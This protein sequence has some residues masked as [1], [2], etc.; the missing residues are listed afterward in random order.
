MGKMSQLNRI[1]MVTGATSGIGAASAQALAGMGAT[2]VLVG[3]NSKK[4]EATVDRIRHETGNRSVDHLTADLSSQASVRELAERFRSRYPRLHV[5]I[6]NAGAIFLKRQLSA[7]G[8]EMTWALNHLGYFLLTNLLL[9]TLISNA[10]ARIVNVA[11]CGHEL[12]RG[13]NFDDLQGQRGYKGFLAYHRS[14]LANLLF[15]FELARRLEGT[16]VTANALHPGLVATHIGENN[17]WVWR[18]LKPV[19]S[20]F[21]NIRYI[22]AEEGARTITHLAMAPEL[23]GLS[24]QYFVDRKVVCSSE[25]SRD[26]SAARRLWE[27]SE[28][29]I[30]PA[31]AVCS[32]PRGQH[33]GSLA[34]GGAGGGP[35]LAETRVRY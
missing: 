28:V 18:V 25:A 5:L 1:V 2:V 26:E 20:R 13:L 6:N 21:Y 19:V 35:S 17:G 10:P 33:G 3:R 8:I 29:M 30:A 24:G 4:C 12:V 22:G 11:S 9:E 14:K 34:G 23:E 27:V 7:D 32:V 15:T 16:R 31:V